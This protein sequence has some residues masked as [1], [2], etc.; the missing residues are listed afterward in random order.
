MM[1]IIL[2]TST[3]AL[4]ATHVRYAP[5]WLTIWIPAGLT[6]VAASRI[7]YWWRSRECE[8]EEAEVLS[9]LRFT[10]VLAVIIAVSFTTWSL[11]L[12]SYSSDGYTRSHVAFYMA[13]TV[14]SCIF[15]LMHL[16]SAAIIVTAIV[17]GAFI[18]FFFA[19]GFPT[20]IAIAVNIALVSFSM[21][22]ILSVNYR[23]FERMIIAQQQTEALSDENLR[24]ANMDSLTSLPNRRALFLRLEKS[25]AG[26]SDKKPASV[27][28]GIIDLD[29]FKAVNDLYGHSMGDRL[30]V[31]VGKRLTNLELPFEV[32]VA[33]L[34]GDEFALISEAVAT[35]A[36][37]ECGE[38][39]CAALRR[40]FS[41]P[42]GT[43]IIAGSLGIAVYPEMASSADELFDRA[44][45]ALY[46]SKRN[47]RGNLV[48]FN[49][50]HDAELRREARIEQALKLADLE[51]E[52]SVV[53]QPIFDVNLDR[54][55]CF[56]ALARWNSPIVGPVSPADFIPI[57]ER[58]GIVSGLTK[59][60][61][62]KA[63][64]AA[65]KWPNHMQLSFN[66]SAHDINSAEAVIGLIGIIEASG[67]DAKRLHLEITETSFIHDFNHV[68]ESVRLLRLLGC[69]LML[70]DFGTGYSSLTSLHLL[71][72]TKIKIDRSFIKNLQAGSSS[73]KIIKS[74]LA[75]SREMGIG[76]IVEGVESSEQL[77]LL[78]RL[79]VSQI[80]GY[81]YSP[82]V[83][84]DKLD[85]FMVPPRPYE[86]L[87]GG[88]SV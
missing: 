67:F 28:L 62:R 14:I 46:H 87:D 22:M 13:I 59:P 34:G 23:N 42:E 71:P 81:F 66:L 47:K 70:D 5:T 54:T 32:F 2:L 1:Y 51:S 74:L 39:I 78:R 35:S 65:C 10:N 41:L 84:A 33:R 3:L 25:L 4:A 15:C 11:T 12:Y 37:I 60:L 20:L 49:E 61:L 45:Y 85:A 73:Y 76:C 44:D 56:E 17:N 64:A 52:L 16:R 43:V 63:L 6:L 30:L 38:T 50:A 72:L 83:P 55:V 77:E 82:P 18:I 69:G 29:G 40:P 58:A 9:A 36:L 26:K 24:L 57:A 79:G 21:L 7:F 68:E 27:A 8:L 31:E 19:S 80:Q 48:L 75:L 53:F 88:V 86:F